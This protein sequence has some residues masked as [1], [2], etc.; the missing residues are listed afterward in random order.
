MKYTVF[1]WN[2]TKHISNKQIIIASNVRPA[3]G[4]A[5]KVDVR[6]NWW[7]GRQM[8]N[9]ERDFL[10]NNQFEV[11]EEYDTLREAMNSLMLDL[12]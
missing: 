1:K 7:N 5:L 4:E 10:M 2:V 12:L 6:F 3:H 8:Y 11:R 9:V